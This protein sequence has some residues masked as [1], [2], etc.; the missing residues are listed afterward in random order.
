MAAAIVGHHCD[1]VDQQFLVKYE[2]RIL[3]VSQG[4]PAQIAD[5][6]YRHAGRQRQALEPSVVDG[7]H[8]D[9]LCRPARDWCVF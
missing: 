8:L 6:R 7:P 2:S 5:A 4:I 1:V 9:L 3:Q